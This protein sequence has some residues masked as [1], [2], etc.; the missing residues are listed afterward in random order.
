MGVSVYKW[1]LKP[2]DFMRSPLGMSAYGEEYMTMSRALGHKEIREKR[3]QAKE[4]KKSR[5][6]RKELNEGC[7]ILEVLHF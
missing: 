6:V 3:R 4:S 2:W 1:Y 7:G 5:Q